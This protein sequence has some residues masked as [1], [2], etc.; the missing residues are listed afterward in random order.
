MSWRMEGGKVCGTRGWEIEIIDEYRMV[1]GRASR[2]VTSLV[3]LLVVS[4][5]LKVARDTL[6]RELEIH[7]SI[8][9]VVKASTLHLDISPVNGTAIKQSQNSTIIRTWLC[10]VRRLERL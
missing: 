1:S 9:V 5:T 4:L 6:T 8:D 7:A 10:S 3:S 2:P